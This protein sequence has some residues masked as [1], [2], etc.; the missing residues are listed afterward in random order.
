MLSRFWGGV[1]S[2]EGERNKLLA[3]ISACKPDPPCTAGAEQGH[4][5]SHFHARAIA[6]RGILAYG[7]AAEDDRALEFV[8]RAYEFSLTQGIP[9]MGWI[10]CLPVATNMCEACALGDLVGLGIRLSD[11]GL[12]D[13]WDDVDAVV[14]NHL[15]EQQLVSTDLLERI[16]A[17]C[18]KACDCVKNAEPGKLSYDNALART[19]GTFAGLSFATDIPKPWVMQCCTGNATQG[20]YYAWEGVVREDVDT[21]Q[22]NLFLNRAARLVDVDSYLPHEGRL[23]VR[24]KAARRVAIRIPAWVSRSHLRTDVS[25]TQRLQRWIHNSLIFDDL[26]PGDAVTLTFPV[27][28]MKLEYTA[29][30]N[31]PA[32]TVYKCTFRAST[33]VDITPHDDLPTSYP[34]YARSHLRTDEAPMKTLD[35]F[36]PGRIISHW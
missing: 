6:L 2:V 14:R 15:V 35:R 20:L 26:K 24:N 30:A 23:V 36:V 33:L 3:H 17:A 22:V 7:R 32:E 34:M 29:N 11:A 16:S 9:R 10:N 12:G 4:W 1:P 28:E 19:I 21:A 13:Y 25:G 31:S 27:R 5:Y 8:R 18:P